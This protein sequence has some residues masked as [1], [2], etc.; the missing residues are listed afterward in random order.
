MEH[1]EENEK[2]VLYLVF[3]YLT[4]DLKRYMDRNGKGPSN[5]LPKAT[6]KVQGVCVCVCVFSLAALSFSP[7]SQPQNAPPPPPHHH[8]NPTKQTNK[9]TNRACCTSC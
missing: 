3:E 1:V 8:Q 9:Q 2:Q 7:L 5:P 4:T 6:V